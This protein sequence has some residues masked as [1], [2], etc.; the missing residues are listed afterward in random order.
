MRVE[1]T[2]LSEGELLTL[3]FDEDLQ[4]SLS[5]ANTQALKLIST[6]AFFNDA[7]APKSTYVTDLEQNENSLTIHCTVPVFAELRRAGA[8]NYLLFL[9]P[10]GQPAEPVSSQNRQQQPAA[11][12]SEKPVMAD[13]E[14]EGEDYDDLLVLARLQTLQ[15]RYEQARETVAAIP[16]ESEEYA[17]G[18]L[19]LGDVESRDGSEKDAVAHF[20]KALKYQHTE[21]AASTNLALFYQQKGDPVKAEQ[22]WEHVLSLNDAGVA[23]FADRSDE[24]D[25]STSGSAGDDKEEYAGSKIELD[26]NT[27]MEFFNSSF[28]IVVA[29]LLFLGGGVGTAFMVWRKK[30]GEKKPKTP[31]EDEKD[32]EVFWGGDESAGDG[33]GA[34]ADEIERTKNSSK[35][36]TDESA[37]MDVSE[38][39]RKRLVEMHNQ[40]NSIREIA[41]ITGMS[42]DII[43][44]ALQMEGVAVDV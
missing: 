12:E 26:S 24:E 1:S 36:S 18:Q 13:S 4:L 38:E 33:L 21:A 10:T 25:V 20:E 7:L 16:K 31:K 40:S 35:A 6:S 41:E 32:E 9:R 5:G 30:R 37:K 17:W 23:P 42:Q 14:F 3:R 39:T 28:L 27:P 34:L 44:M 2:V 11:S 22:M 8:G 19:V 15:G 43:R 29:L